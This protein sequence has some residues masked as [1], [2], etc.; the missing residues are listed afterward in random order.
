MTANNFSALL[1]TCMNAEAAGDIE[2]IMQLPPDVLAQTGPQVSRRVFAMALNAILLRDLLE[3]VPSAAAYVADRRQAGHR[4]MFDHG[5]LRTI[6][7]PTHLSAGCGL[8]AG[9]SV[10]TRVLLPLGY[11]RREV[12]PLRKLRMTG[13]SYAH[14]DGLH[15]IRQHI[16][17][18]A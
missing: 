12:Y 2:R 6:S 13:R 5:A 17:G 4:I 10:I 15:D 9:E 18:R 16:D 14:V 11:V 1:N 8:P 3:R 7:L